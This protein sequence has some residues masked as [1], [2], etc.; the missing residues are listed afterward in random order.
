LGR[1]SS[2]SSLVDVEQ[3]ENAG[4]DGDVEDQPRDS[5]DV[6]GVTP[7]VLASFASGSSTRRRIG[8]SEIARPTVTARAAHLGPSSAIAHNDPNRVRPKTRARPSRSRGVRQMLAL[9]ARPLSGLEETD[10]PQQCAS[11]RK[12]NR[13]HRLKN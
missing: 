13:D 7:S 1:G 4:D 5:D 2:P 8:I 3:D 12:L 10:L 11:D 6:I 9:S